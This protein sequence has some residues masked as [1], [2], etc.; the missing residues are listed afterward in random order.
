MANSDAANWAIAKRLVHWGIA[1]AVVTALLAPKPEHGDGMLH[2]AA[3]TTALALVLVRLCWRL[4]GGV[5]PFFRDALRLKWP[6][7]SKGARGFAP[8]FMQV[9]RLIGLSF[10]AAIPVAA[11]LGLAGIAQGEESAL[12]EAHE[13][14]GALMIG[15]VIAHAA[16][17][18]LFAVLLKYDL[19]GVTLT[20][21][22]RGFGEGGARG[23]IGAALG[24][25]VG[26]GALAYVWGP[27][28]VA[29]KAAALEQA[30]DSEHQGDGREREAE[31]D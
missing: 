21:A 23:G 2:I 27:F 8:F 11:A 14:M 3:G 25:L 18:V 16:A 12:L 1:A 29:S 6:D 31:G 4:L 24:V 20:G 7:A 22:A 9:G 19:V 28:D 10:L 13:A 15:L 17:I 5:R 30:E 26:L